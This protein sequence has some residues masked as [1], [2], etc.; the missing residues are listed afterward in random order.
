MQYYKWQQEKKQREKHQRMMQQQIKQSEENLQKNMTQISCRM[1]PHC[2]SGGNSQ[3]CVIC[4]RN[5]ARP[6]NAPPVDYF[7]PKIP[8]ITVLP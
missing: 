7:K 8:G 5:Q 2:K 1:I 4:S 3:G 6:L